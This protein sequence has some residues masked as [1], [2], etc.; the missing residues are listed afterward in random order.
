M[1]QKGVVYLFN[2][3]VGEM[4]RLQVEG[5]EIAILERKCKDKKNIYETKKNEDF[6]D[7]VIP[8]VL[9]TLG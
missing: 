2:A 9:P 4:V 1:V 7:I 3:R 8:G 5:R 6:V